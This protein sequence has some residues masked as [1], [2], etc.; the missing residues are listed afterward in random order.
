MG[1]AASF[2]RVHTVSVDEKC[3]PADE[4]MSFRAKCGAMKTILHTG[5]VFV[6]RVLSLKRS[7]DCI[8]C[9]F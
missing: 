7:I 8:F 5:A 6:F 1:S 2:K 3:S 9:G 4:A